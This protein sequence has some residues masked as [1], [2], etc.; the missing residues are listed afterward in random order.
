MKEFMNSEELARINNEKMKSMN[1]NRAERNQ[2]KRR[3]E[4]FRDTINKLSPA[5]WEVIEEIANTRTD[6]KI[7]EFKYIIDRNISCLLIEYLPEKTYEEIDEIERYYASLVNEDYE[8]C[9]KLEE[10]WKGNSELGTKT[11]Q[12]YENEVKDSSCF[13][14]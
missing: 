6:Q 7:E 13:I 3:N 14:P 12:R 1:L 2:F 4:K 10:S 8:K 5:Q 11:M 9:I